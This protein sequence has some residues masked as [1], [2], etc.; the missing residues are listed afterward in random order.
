MVHARASWSLLRLILG[1]AWSMRE[2]WRSLQVRSGY[3][4]RWS[5][6]RTNLLS[7]RIMTRSTALPPNYSLTVSRR[8]LSRRRLSWASG[9]ES[10]IGERWSLPYGVAVHQDEELLQ[11]LLPPHGLCAGYDGEDAGVFSLATDRAPSWPRMILGMACMVNLLAT[12][13]VETSS[14]L[15][16]PCL[17]LPP[18]LSLE[19]STREGCR[20]DQVSE[21][22]G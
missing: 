10:N 4:L 16:S 12:R 14:H 11:L 5:L 22:G 2:E 17:M 15:L 18:R 19:L 8:S 7:F 9:V 20:K 1:M 21:D 13:S 6:Q 3:L